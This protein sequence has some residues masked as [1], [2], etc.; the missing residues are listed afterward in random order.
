MRQRENA[1]AGSASSSFFTAANLSAEM[2]EDSS[3]R[4]LHAKATDL[5][6]KGLASG[7]RL[8]KFKFQLYVTVIFTSV[9][10]FING[11]NNSSHLIS[12]LEYG[13]RHINSTLKS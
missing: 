7:A 1:K 6:F 10:S 9:F 3:G 8:T 12:C 4:T 13:N 11:Q 2:K 5:K